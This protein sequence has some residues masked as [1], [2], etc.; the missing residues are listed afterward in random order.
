MLLR[1]TDG[2]ELELTVAGYEFPDLAEL[3]D[4]S[5]WDANWLVVAGR[6][7]LADGRTWSFRDPSLVVDEAQQLGR[8][9]LAAA[10]GRVPEVPVA[11]PKEPADRR[12]LVFVEPN[13][14]FSVA[15]R[16][17][18]SVAV[19]VWLSHETVAPWVEEP[20]AF[21]AQ[22]IVLVVP[23]AELAAAGKVWLDAM[24]AFPRRG[25]AGVAG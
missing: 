9:L 15:R 20:W 23:A 2:T 14:A 11:E 13:L 10:D 21:D 1:S 8:W 16:E 6:L 25:V 7:V 5:D 19:R 12:M 18:G 17:A 24:S 22:E 3:A 4:A